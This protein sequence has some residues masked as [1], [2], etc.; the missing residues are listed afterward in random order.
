[1]PGEPG[2]GGAEGA[3]FPGGPAKAA[4]TERPR[5]CRAEGPGQAAVTP[6]GAGRA[7]ALGPGVMAGEPSSHIPTQVS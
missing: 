7:G 3:G 6:G 5:G 1:M 2:G 4:L